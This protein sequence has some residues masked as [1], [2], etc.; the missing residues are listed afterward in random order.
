[1][2]YSKNSGVL[3]VSQLTQSIKTS[4]E[5][6]YRFIHIQGEISNLRIPYSGHIYFTLKDKN[7]QIRAVMFKGQ[8]KYLL[9]QLED[10]QSVVCH[11]RLS[12]YEPRGEYQII[13]DTVEPSKVGPATSIRS[14]VTSD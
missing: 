9:Q 2:E 6:Q 13:V 10:G 8:T 5:L 1:M 14:A 12:V 4:L 3:S 11:G 7:A